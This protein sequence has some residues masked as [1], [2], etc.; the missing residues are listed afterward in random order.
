MSL[1]LGLQPAP[2]R[3]AP[4]AATAPTAGPAP[5]AQRSDGRDASLSVIRLAKAPFATKPRCHVRLIDRTTGKAVARGHRPAPH[6][7]SRRPRRHEA[8]GHLPAQA[9]RQEGVG[10][11]AGDGDDPVD[12]SHLATG[13]LILGTPV[14]KVRTR[15]RLPHR[16]RRT[17]R[18]PQRSRAARAGRSRAHAQRRRGGAHARRPGPDGRARDHQRGRLAVG[19]RS[20]ST[21]R[22]P[23]ARRCSA[24]PRSPSTAA[25]SRATRARASSSARPTSPA[26]RSTAAAS[27]SPGTSRSR[28]A[29][30]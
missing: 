13:V 9:H 10:A 11:Q 4:P 23:T 16:P 30:S 15:D 1:T 12:P 27:R 21:R 25:T 29:R 24:S 6:A 19:A 14:A 17:R 8:Q 2:P 18:G 20:C 28:R 22:W 5:T 3:S 7:A 26:T